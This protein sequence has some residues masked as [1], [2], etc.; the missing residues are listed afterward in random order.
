MSTFFSLEDDEP[1][2]Y[3]AL[4]HTVTT[5]IDDHVDYHETINLENMYAE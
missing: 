4:P 2:E 5:H 1:L 3:Y